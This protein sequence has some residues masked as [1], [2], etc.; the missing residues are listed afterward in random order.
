MNKVITINLG[1]TAWQ[2]E[3]G[4]YDT[5]RAYLETA[6]ARLQGNPDRDEIISDIEWAIAEKFRGL[7]SGH[8]TV[9]LNAEVATVL[10]EM[11]PIEAETGGTGAGP[12]PGA[13]VPPPGAAPRAE[14][15]SGAPV[16]PRRLYRIR[17]GGMFAGVCNGI[18][19]YFN[20]APT[21]VRL[22]F[23]CM[24]IVWGVGVLAYIV[25]MIVIPEAHTPAERAAASGAGRNFWG[26]AA[27]PAFTTQEFSRRAHAGYYEAMKGFPDRQAR[28]EWKRRFKHDMRDWW[29]CSWAHGCVPPTPPIPPVPP[30]AGYALPMFSLLHGAMNILWICALISLLTSGG[31]FGLSLPANVPVWMAVVVL[32]LLHGLLEWPFKAARRACYWGWG[33]RPGASW[34]FLFALD[35]LVW[36]AVVMVLLWLA[37]H[38]I[39][40]LH[41]ALRNLPGMVHQAVTDIRSW[42]NSK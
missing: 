34:A 22:A 14:S 20:I 16:P 27:G 8:K 36:F 25:M 39:P 33:P 30:A 26:G 18:G 23:V 15:A 13:D 17:E 3:E 31:I 4:G 5:L 10:R 2:L 9:V 24:V 28:R 37:C 40:E 11:G 6:A 29:R 38:H 41:D 32:F 7:I 35:G 19:A 21:F 1:G 12:A 42:W